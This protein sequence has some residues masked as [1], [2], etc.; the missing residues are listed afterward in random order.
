MR[1]SQLA[2]RDAFVPVDDAGGTFKAL[3]PPFRMSSS[4]MPA[5][6]FS[7]ALG[8][9]NA[10]VLEGKELQAKSAKSKAKA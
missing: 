1:P 3:R 9:H 6:T 7:S 4:P 2:H 10:E 8:Q 5:R